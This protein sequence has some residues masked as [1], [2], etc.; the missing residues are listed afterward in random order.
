MGIETP[1]NFP[2]WRA[3]PVFC[4]KFPRMIPITMA[5]KIHS[6]RKRSRRPRLLNAE[7]LVEGPSFSCFSTSVTGSWGSPLGRIGTGSDGEYSETGLDFESLSLNMLSRMIEVYV[8]HKTCALD[9]R[10]GSSSQSSLDFLRGDMWEIDGGNERAVDMG[11]IVLVY[12]TVLLKD[13]PPIGWQ[14]FHL[15]PQ[16]NGLPYEAGP[17]GSQDLGTLWRW[18]AR[19]CHLDSML[20]AGVSL[21]TT[22]DDRVRGCC[23]W[24]LEKRMDTNDQSDRLS[25]IHSRRVVI[26]Q[27]R[28]IIK[29]SNLHFSLFSQ[30]NQPGDDNFRK[31][32]LKEI[33]VRRSSW[34]KVQ[35]HL[36]FT[37]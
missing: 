37:F 5:K 13:I 29:W 36:Y 19:K 7:T 20:K 9:N 3:G 32:R 4:T 18:H 1:T 16:F 2:F 21:D 25:D 10:V 30:E 8:W 14:P 17:C 12:Q 33:E 28:P 35:E 27:A 31:P 6:A 11:A 22:V 15:L 34:Y 26:G 23:G 24:V